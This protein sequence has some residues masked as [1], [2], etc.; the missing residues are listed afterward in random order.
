MKKTLL[1][2]TLLMAL[3]LSTLSAE[4]FCWRNLNP[5][6]WGTCPKCER[7]ASC[8]CKKDKCNPCKKEKV[9]PVKKQDNCGCKKQDPCKKQTTCDP[10]S[11]MQ[12]EMDD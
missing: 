9:C 7:T 1:T 6:S 2:T 3:S 5:A 11:K 10:C 12:E 8:K 4:A